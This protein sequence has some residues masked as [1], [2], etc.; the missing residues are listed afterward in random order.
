MFQLFCGK[1]SSNM[2]QMHL[3]I[4]GSY[5]KWKHRGAVKKE[6]ILIADTSDIGESP[7]RFFFNYF[8][9][10]VERVLAWI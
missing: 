2:I 9:F 5:N 1:Q 6:L 7:L 8:F 3:M 10:R 4:R